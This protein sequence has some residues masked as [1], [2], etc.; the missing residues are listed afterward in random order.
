M[1]HRRALRFRGVDL[2]TQPKPSD[3]LIRDA[4]PLRVVEAPG[5]DVMNPDGTVTVVIQRPCA[6]RG[7]G[8]RIFEASM[9]EANAGVFKGWPMFDNHDSPLARRARAGL[10][11][12]PSELG[13]VIR[14]SW[15]DP[16]Y[17]DPELDERFDLGK[18]AVLGKAA[19][20]DP[21]E[22]LVRKIPEAIKVSVN[23]AA[24]ALKRGRWQGRTV[25]EGWVVE[26]Y[27]ADPEDSSV[28]LVTSAGAGGDVRRVLQACH[29][30]SHDATA[31]LD[32][33]E[34]DDLVLY[35]REH[36]DS[37][38][39]QLGGDGEVNL[40]EAF[41][42][43]EFS[44][45]LEAKV[46]EQIDE[47]GLVPKDEFDQR[48]REAAGQQSR[49]RD[50]RDHAKARILEAKGLTQAARDDLLDR[51]AARDLGNGILE[52]SAQLAVA[53]EMDGETV[54]K[55]ALKLLDERLDEAIQRERNKIAEA[56]PTR[57]GGQG[58]TTGA[59]SEGGEGSGATWRSAMQRS[60]TDPDEAYGTAKPDSQGDE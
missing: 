56:N 49:I 52:A 34:D 39:P 28:D 13:G 58:A 50:H 11:R 51:F 10:P 44:A 22:A 38:I 1:R 45:V 48:V 16:E 21:M 36:R 7:P 47:R 3:H 41:E 37:V 6:G 8:D 53:D 19:L 54:T 33:V 5:G 57:V 20:S 2:L 14:E 9:L 17:E 23:G 31:L 42:S 60:G 59:V 29:D 12:P 46:G 30:P 4:L 35:V 40:K 32:A 25:K 27:I 55:P 18:G 43:P 24:K 26:G 15:W